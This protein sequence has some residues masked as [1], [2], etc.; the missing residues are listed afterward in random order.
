[1]SL[2]TSALPFK[3]AEQ[4]CKDMLFQCNCKDIVNQL[5]MI[6][7]HKLIYNIHREDFDTKWLKSLK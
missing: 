7:S 3:N 2:P 1:M 4:P 6:F 5:S